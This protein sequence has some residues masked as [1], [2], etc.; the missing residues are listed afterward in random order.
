MLILSRKRNEKIMIGD[1]IS[2]MIVD[3]R[4][5][6]VQIGIHAAQ[7]AANFKQAFDKALVERAR[8]NDVAVI[9]FAGHGSQAPDKNGDE[10]DNSD[11]TLMFHDARTKG[12]R[13]MLDDEFNQILG[14]LAARD[15]DQAVLD[16]K[17]NYTGEW[18]TYGFSP[19]LQ[20]AGADLIELGVPFSD[21]MADGPVIQQASER[22]IANG[23]SLCSVLDTVRS[24]REQ[25]GDTPVV[26]MGYLNPIERYGYAAFADDASAAGV[27]GVL[28]VGGAQAVAA[29]APAQLPLEVLDLGDVRTH[30]D[31]ADDPMLAFLRTHRLRLCEQ[32]DLGAIQCVGVGPVT[33]KLALHHEGHHRGSGG[34]HTADGYR[35]HQ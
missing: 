22:A 8:A 12:V 2:I 6:Q 20:S 5:D 18:Y 11:E 19:L 21:P 24:F 14:K 26:L 33:G 17:L 27:D 28:A 31:V 15:S 30:P 7:R 35:R 29:L 25:D 34:H 10:A 32:P 1:E 23:V 4:G 16:I 3:I 9:F 13:D